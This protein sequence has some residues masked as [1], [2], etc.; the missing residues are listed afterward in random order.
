MCG[1]K[2]FIQHLCSNG[3][4]AVMH[5]AGDRPQTT[6]RYEHNSIDQTKYP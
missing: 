4:H 6:T 2:S 5:S 3:E 1:L